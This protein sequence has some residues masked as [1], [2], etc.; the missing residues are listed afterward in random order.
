MNWLYNSFTGII[1][2]LANLVTIGGLIFVIKEINQAKESQKLAEKDYRVR[3][4]KDERQKAIEM[5]ELYA[6]EL[7]GRISYLN[8]VYKKCG[9]FKYFK[10]A[11]Y[12]DFKDFDIYELEKFISGKIEVGELLKMT[13][14]IKLEILVDASQ[15]LHSDNK[16]IIDDSLEIIR[17]NDFIQTHESHDEAAIAT[18]E[19]TEKKIEKRDEMEQRYF[20]AKLK[21]KKYELYYNGEFKT[22]LCETLNKLEYFCMYFN[23]GVADEET[24]YQSLHQSF[25]EMVKVLYF[26]IASGNKTGK[27]KYYTNIIELYNKWSERDLKLQEEEIE[28]KRKTTHKKERIKK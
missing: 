25:L 11:G 10:C 13:E 22:I 18:L 20:Q 8:A 28:A 19:D 9:V 2:F 15:Y 4:E 12:D 5:A 21:Y 24:V 26:K 7:I 27:D 6:K 17:L 23:S 16:Q 3:N 1:G 14:N